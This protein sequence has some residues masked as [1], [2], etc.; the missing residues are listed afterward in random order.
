MLRYLRGVCLRPGQ[1]LE[2]VVRLTLVSKP[3]CT[4][5]FLV[6][7]DRHLTLHPKWLLYLLPAPLS[8]HYIHLPTY[9]SKSTEIVT[10]MH[11]IE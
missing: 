1:G 3:L 8:L 11:T 7:S 10:F 5:T 6:L 4:S 9:L 2:A